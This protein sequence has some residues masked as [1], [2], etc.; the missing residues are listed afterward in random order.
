MPISGLLIEAGQHTPFGSAKTAVNP[1]TTK[2]L[3]PM[4]RPYSLANFKSNENTVF[5][6]VHDVWCGGVLAEE[7][8]WVRDGWYGFGCGYT[9]PVRYGYGTGTVRVR[10][11][12]DTWV[13]S[14]RY[15]GTQRVRF[16]Y[17]C[18]VPMYTVPTVPVPST[19]IAAKI[20]TICTQIAAEIAADLLDRGRCRLTRAMPVA[21]RILSRSFPRVNG[22]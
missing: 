1:K 10:Y 20:R 11:G 3:P 22:R 17:P 2:H 8:R 6:W 16:A 15:M 9:V 4:I 19:Q 13:R 5:Y 21:P 7:F 18:T 14:V 12:Y